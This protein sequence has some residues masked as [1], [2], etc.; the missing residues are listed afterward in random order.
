M[1]GECPFTHLSMQFSISPLLHLFLLAVSQ[2]SQTPTVDSA[3]VQGLIRIVVPWWRVMVW[4]ARGACHYEAC[5][6]AFKE[7]RP[8]KIKQMAVRITP[9]MGCTCSPHI[10]LPQLLFNQCLKNPLGAQKLKN[11]WMLGLSTQH[12]ITRSLLTPVQ[13]YPFH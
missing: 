8:R 7:L 9:L 10:L 1:T 2:K 11:V 5:Q 6:R 3:H 4:L 13:P 12:Q